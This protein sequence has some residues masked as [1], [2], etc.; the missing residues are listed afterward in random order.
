MAN[1]RLTTAE[2][3]QMKQ[4]VVKGT[5]PEDIANHFGIAVS[6]VHNYKKR[7]RDQGLQFPSV[8]GQRPI[9]ASPLQ[10]VSPAA[11]P[12]FSSVPSMQ[13]G[14]DT[15]IAAQTGEFSFV[16]NGVSVKVSSEAKNV[17]I[18]KN[19]MEITF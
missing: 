8:R 18:G 14:S 3:E 4:M 13:A 16:I 17:S 15:M 9:G 2:M 6:S 12:S 5:A 19:G 1:K 11:G 10:P 7:F